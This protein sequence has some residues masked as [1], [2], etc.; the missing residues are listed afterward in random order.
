MKEKIWKLDFIKIK[1]FS[2][3]KDTTKKMKRLSQ[4]GR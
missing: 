1:N 2:F 4:T 3:L